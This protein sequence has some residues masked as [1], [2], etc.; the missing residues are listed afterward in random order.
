MATAPCTVPLLH[1]ARHIY[2]EAGVRLVKE[3]SH[4]SF[5]HDL[6]GQNWELKL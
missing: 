1:A 6:M 4:H 5:G 2:A 3:E